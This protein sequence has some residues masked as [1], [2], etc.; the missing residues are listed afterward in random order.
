VKY[1]LIAVD[2]DGTLLSPSGQVTPR[3]KAAIHKALLAGLQICFATGRNFTE[4][5]AVLDAVAHYD[6]AVFVGGALIIDT[7]TRLTLHRT[8]MDAQLARDLCRFFESHGHAALALQDRSTAGVDYL[9]TRD[10]DLDA[11]TD[12]WL[13]INHA[14]VQRTAG[15]AQHPHDHTIRVGIAA[16]AKAARPV[17]DELRQAFGDRVVAHCLITPG[18][19]GVVEAFD[20]SVN[21]WQG[22]LHVAH[23]HN[24]QPREI[25]AVGDDVNDLSMIQNAGLGIAMGNACP[26]LLQCA[27]QVIGRNDHDGLAIFLEELLAAP[28]AARN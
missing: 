27:A 6:P 8:L 18:G 10:F 22:I 19:L 7:R 4:S 1:K 2:L 11:A 23:R 17:Y 14:T 21:K 13:K 12:Q 5:Q 20:P 24:V 28:A 26:E 25:I 3:T 16:P 9:A 15:L